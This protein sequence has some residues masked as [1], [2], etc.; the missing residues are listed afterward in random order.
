MKGA[1]IQVRVEASGGVGGGI[2]HREDLVELRL[3]EEKRLLPGR[4][5]VHRAEVTGGPSVLLKGYLHPEKARGDAARE[6]GAL[7]GLRDRGLPVPEPL[8]LASDADGRWW[9][10]TA[11][12]EDA[13]ELGAAW[14]RPCSGEELARGMESLVALVHRSHEVGVWQSDLHLGN[15]LLGR[16]G[17]LWMVDAASHRG[18]KGDLSRKQRVNNWALLRANLL[19]WQRDAFDEALR[20]AVSHDV[21]EGVRRATPRV[22]ARRLRRYRRKC[23]RRCSEFVRE[24]EGKRVLLRRREL[25]ADWIQDLAGQSPESLDKRYEV[26]KRASRCLV[27]AGSQGELEWVLKVHW[28][29]PWRRLGRVSR[30]R[31]SWVSGHGL[32]L[33]GVGTPDPLAFWEGRLEGGWRFDGLLMVRDHGVPLQ[34]WVRENHPPETRERLRDEVQFFFGALEELRASHG[35]TKASNFHVGPGADLRVIDLDSFAWGGLRWRR[36]RAKDR[37]RFERNAVKFPEGE[38]VFRLDGLVRSGR[39]NQGR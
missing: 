38:A 14:R 35:D 2:P 13:I 30:A 39:L 32:R 19:M 31:R 26:L 7:E 10:A 9:V 34:Q 11:F 5:R 3:G 37:E 6:W 18:F 29:E 28:S 36:R 1:L 4:R 20:T 33:L 27:V 8:F 12:L 21:R 17:E 24:E 23:Q 15:F 16:E 25:G 22:L